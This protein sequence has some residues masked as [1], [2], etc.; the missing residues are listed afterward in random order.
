M[1]QMW[2]CEDCPV[3]CTVTIK[4][5]GRIRYPAPTSCLYDLTDAHP[6]W[7]EIRRGQAVTNPR[8]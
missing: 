4:S 6:V 1:K 7:V 5:E 2:K 3:P 8:R